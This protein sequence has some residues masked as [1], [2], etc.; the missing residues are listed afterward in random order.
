MNALLNPTQVEVVNTVTERC[1]SCG[2]AA[3]LGVRL[4]GG[5]ELSFCGHHANR[6]AGEIAKMANRVLVEAGFAWTGS[7]RTA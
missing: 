6:H 4:S 5:G 3:K 7:S 1:D 2:A